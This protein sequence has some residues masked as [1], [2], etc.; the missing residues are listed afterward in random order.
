M[1][2]FEDLPIRFQNG[3]AKKYY[4]I[5]KRH[6]FSL[7]AKRTF[8]LLAALILFI[9]FILPMCII[10]ILVVLDSKGGAIFS[11]K[12]ITKYGREFQILKF[13]TMTQN[14]Q[15]SSLITLKDDFRITKIG[16]TLRKY[17]LD[18]LPQLINIISGDMSF[19]GAR[20]EVPKYADKYT[21]E[22]T[23]TLLLR[24]GVTS[25][26]SIKYRNEEKLLANC[27]NPDEFY[28]KTVMPA[29]MKY[30]IEY[31]QDFSFWL[32]IK[33]IFQTVSAVFL[34]NGKEEAYE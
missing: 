31:I 7:A 21:D 6:K 15:D 5:L 8:D 26:A 10:A 1:K 25:T 32:D 33:I 22:M 16:K 11:Q 27:E 30:N 20:P 2:K 17:R 12:R 18:E 24:A 14:T 9:I 4:D 28:E 13:R 34:K 19:V 23:A 29:K 3:T